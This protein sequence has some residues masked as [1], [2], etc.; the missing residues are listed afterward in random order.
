MTPPPPEE[1]PVPDSLEQEPVAP[2]RE[3]REAEPETVEIEPPEDDM[4]LEDALEGDHR[5]VILRE[6]YREV[7]TIAEGIWVKDLPPPARV[8]E[9][10]SVSSWYEEQFSPLGLRPLSDFYDII[11]KVDQRMRAGSTREDLQKYL[12]EVN[13]AQILLS[14]RDMFQRNR[15]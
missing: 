1:K 11:A 4:T 13:F 12:K 2:A 15:I 6:L 9:K 10:V 14:L 3:D 5:Q 8:W 7:T